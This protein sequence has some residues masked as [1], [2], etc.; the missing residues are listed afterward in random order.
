MQSKTTQRDLMFR[1]FQIHKYRPEGMV[2]T[3]TMTSQ[4][5]VTRMLELKK[6]AN[7]NKTF[8]LHITITHI[9]TKAVADS[10]KNYPLLFSFFNNNK[11]IENQELVI[12]I[13][14]DVE[15]HV[16]YIVL[17]NPGSKSLSTIAEEF[18]TELDKIH[19]GNGTFFHVI[20]QLMENKNRSDNNDPIEFL[21]QH[22]GN[23]PISNFGSFHID[24]GTLA[25]AQ[26]VIAGLCVGSVKSTAYKQ[27]DEWIEAMMLP[28][29]ISFDHRPIDGAYVGRFLNEVKKLLENPDTIFNVEE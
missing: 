3:V 9:V 14:V 4:I 24:S 7:S 23:F 12:S 11:I 2:P 17:H 15:Q 29:T 1:N 5:N 21:R 28:L 10:L 18:T 26:P 22:L 20:K 25:L 8:P 13:P 27:A 6:I 16:E 19:T